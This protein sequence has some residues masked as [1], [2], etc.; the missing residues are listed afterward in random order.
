MSA[1]N[2]LK[3]K[4]IGLVW[5]I[6]NIDVDSGEGFLVDEGIDLEDA[7]RKANDYMREEEV[8]YGLDIKI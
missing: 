8:E 5:E 3:I 7:I 4:K 1:N 2:A 6:R